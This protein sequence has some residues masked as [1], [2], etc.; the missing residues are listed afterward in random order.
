MKKYGALKYLIHIFTPEPPV[1]LEA[2]KRSEPLKPEASPDRIRNFPYARNLSFTGRESLLRNLRTALTTG[3]NVVLTQAVTGLGGMGKT[4]LALEYAY[5]HEGDYRVIWWVRSEEPATLVA[6]YARLAPKLGLLGYDPAHLENSAGIVRQWLE[7]NPGWLLIFDNSQNPEVLE[8]YLPKTGSGHVIITS[9]NPN[10]E[11]MAKPLEVLEFT[12]D[13]SIEFLLK[14]T[15]QNDKKAAEAL[16]NALGDLPLALEQAGAYIRETPGESLVG[17]LEIFKKRRVGILKLGKPRN[18]PDT[19]ATTWNISIEAARREAHASLDLLNLLSFMAPDQIPKSLLIDGSEHLS[20]PLASAVKDKVELDKSLASLRRYSLISFSGDLL[21]VHRLVQAVTRDRLSRDD[22][23]KW[24]EAA[25]KIVDKA[26]PYDSDNVSTWDVCSAL[27][28]HAMAS[29]GYA[30]EMGA[31]VSSRLLSQV[32]LYL[33]E[34]AEFHAAKSS[35]KR[36]LKIDENAYGPDHPN[37]AR[38][39]NN[40]GTVLKDL[41]D[42]EGARK[43]FKRALKIDEKAYGL[44][45]P[46]VARDVNNL[47]L[48]LQAQ[49]DLNGGRKCFERALK[50]DEKA[51]DPDHPIVARAVNNLGLVLQDLGDLE[52][53]RKCF[54]RAL[55]IDEKAYGPD[56]PTV[57]TDV[58]NLGSVLQDLGE[59][60]DARK[61]YKRALKIDEK[62]YGLDHPIVARDVNNLGSVLQAMGDLGEARKCLERALKVFR[63]RLGEDHPN[64]KLVRRN[65]GLLK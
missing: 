8:K 1:R 57:A 56:H 36:A 22:Q 15:G 46:N 62:V 25:V 44:D 3:R 12:R 16:A 48:V 38:Y 31:A 33:S 60:D 32:G 49:G 59:L 39:V 55:R 11:T 37:V 54:E 53:A 20:E 63:D 23:K 40:I 24:A 58:N 47:G 14:R 41:G 7:N 19:I 30:E 26:F 34:R 4:Q 17:Y 18:Y 29:I 50:I 45:H 28:P 65:L 2:E 52:G 27:M 6:D 61:F 64:T 9:K 51:Y 13:E 42:F 10:W 35:I 43:C 21:S 5:R